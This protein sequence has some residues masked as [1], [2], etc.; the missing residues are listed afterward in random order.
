[1][2][3]GLKEL[4]EGSWTPA[5]PISLPL[6]MPLPRR[7]QKDSLWSC[8]RLQGPE[9]GCQEGSL[10]WATAYNWLRL[11]WPLACLETNLT[12][13]LQGNQW[14]HWKSCWTSLFLPNVQIPDGL[15]RK[16][17]SLHTSVFVSAFFLPH[18]TA[19]LLL[20]SYKASS[21][22]HEE[23]HLPLWRVEKLEPT[24][25]PRS[26]S[27]RKP[28][29]KVTARS[30]LW[31]PFSWGLLLAQTLGITG[32]IVAQ[33]G[34]WGTVQSSSVGRRAPALVLHEIGQ[35]RG[36]GVQLTHWLA[37]STFFC[38]LLWNRKYPELFTVKVRNSRFV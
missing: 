7:L 37:V 38:E 32:N 2:R 30:S 4:S 31:S 5:G 25:W 35:R 19:I 26:H 11:S 18:Q 34:R 22:L 13:C 20:L 12:L 1:M 8:H 6:R 9:A 36:K 24:D 3:W 23:R 28:G 27:H 16:K 10:P 21:E 29:I 33:P 14:A 15:G 17:F